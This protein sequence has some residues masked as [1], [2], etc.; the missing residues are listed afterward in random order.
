M[1]EIEFYKKENRWYANLP[2]YI[3]S[4]GTEA[5]CEMV[6]GADEWLDYL[7]KNGNSIT[8]ILSNEPI[9]EQLVLIDKSESDEFGATYMAYTYK[10]EDVNQQIW[11]CPVTLFV[12]GEYPKVIYYK[13]K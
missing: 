11:L 12:F 5:D 1:K 4:G 6:S 9:Q 3:S 2:D 10:E 8:L 13:I 7:S